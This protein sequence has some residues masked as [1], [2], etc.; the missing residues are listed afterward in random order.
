MVRHGWG[1]K[2]HEDKWSEN[3]DA[4][5]SSRVQSRCGSGWG[6]PFGDDSEYYGYS[7]QQIEKIDPRFVTYEDGHVHAVK[8]QQLEEAAMAGF[9]L[10][11]RELRT[12]V[13]GI[14]RAR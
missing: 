1:A 8:H 12:E 7:A 11:V 9:S 5:Y 2:G 10:L 14:H 4:D 6:E 3:E 13:D